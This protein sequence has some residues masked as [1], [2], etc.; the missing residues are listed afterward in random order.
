MLEGFK[1]ESITLTENARKAK[2]AFDREIEQELKLG[3]EY[4]HMPSFASKIVEHAIRIAAVLSL[5]EGLIHI[6]EKRSNSW[7]IHRDSM[8]SGIAIARW[9]LEEVKHLYDQDLE[10]EDEVKKTKVLATLQALA[11]KHPGGVTL[12]DIGRSISKSVMDRKSSTIQPILEKLLQAGKIE[13]T[14]ESKWKPIP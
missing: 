2:T 13:K 7:S 12:R 1:F 10:D 9:H 4:H 8:E 5:F 3:G 11:K 6:R 14:S